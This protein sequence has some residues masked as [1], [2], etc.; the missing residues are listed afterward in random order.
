[1]DPTLLLVAY[2]AAELEHMVAHIVRH[3]TVLIAQDFRIH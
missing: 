1:M 2:L 3:V